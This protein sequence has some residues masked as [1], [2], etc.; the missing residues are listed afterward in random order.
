MTESGNVAKSRPWSSDGT[1]LR[2][3]SR[4]LYVSPNPDGN[5][6]INE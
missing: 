3:K 6:K 1:L 5:A 2:G 4:R